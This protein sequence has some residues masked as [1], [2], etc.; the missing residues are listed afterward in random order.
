MTF[1]RPATDSKPPAQVTISAME[2]F[3]RSSKMAGFLMSPRR[4]NWGPTAGM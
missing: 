1:L 3:W 4:A 2:A